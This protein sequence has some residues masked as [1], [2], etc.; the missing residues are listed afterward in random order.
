MRDDGRDP[1]IHREFHRLELRRH[2]ADRK[3]SAFGAREMRHTLDVRHL[4]N[5]LALGVAVRREAIGTGEKDEQI[6]VDEPRH[7]RGKPVVVAEAQFLDRHGVIL[8]DD[9]HDAARSEQALERVFGVGVASAAIEIEMGEQHLR[10]EE[11]AP[12]E[13][14]AVQPH[15]ARLPDR[16]AGLNRREILRPLGQ[17]EGHQSGTD[18]ATRNDDALHPPLDQ[19]G[20]LAR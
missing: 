8:I 4:G 9:R 14:R 7:L 15:Q 10:D 2:A 11:A 3:L 12:A 1:G 20:N 18:R 16:G 6:G 19:I 5:R 13:E 17:A